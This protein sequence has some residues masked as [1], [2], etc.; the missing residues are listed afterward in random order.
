MIENWWN[1]PDLEQNV[2]KDKLDYKVFKDIL[3]TLDNIKPIFISREE[4]NDKKWNIIDKDWDSETLYLP[5]DLKINELPSIIYRVNKL[6][7]W[8]DFPK[9][10]STN[11]LK[12]KII[13]AVD[14]L[15]NEFSKNNIDQDE[16]KK[17]TKKYFKLYS[18]MFWDNEVSKLNNSDY[19]KQVIVSK[20]NEK[21][22]E[23]EIKLLQIKTKENLSELKSDIEELLSWEIQN[24]F[25]ESFYEKWSNNTRNWLKTITQEEVK[26]IKRNE[27]E[28]EDNNWVIDIWVNINSLDKHERLVRDKIWIDKMKNELDNIRTL[29]NIEDISSMEF[30]ITNKLMR[31]LKEYPYQL[32]NDWYGYEPDKILAYKEAYCVWFSHMWSSFLSELWINHKWLD[33]LQHSA[34]EVNIWWKK[35]LFDVTRRYPRL[36]EFEYWEKKW[37]FTEMNFSRWNKSFYAIPWNSEKIILSQIYNNK[38][39]NLSKWWRDEE[40]IKVYEESLELNPNSS[41]VSSNMSISLS[42]LWKID[43]SIEAAKKSLISYPDNNNAYNSL[44]LSYFKLWKYWDAIESFKDSLR[45][46]PNDSSTYNNI[47]LCL[48]KLWKN[49]E[50]IFSFNHAIKLNPKNIGA[51]D[52]LSE[53][54]DSVWNDKKSS[55]NKYISSLLSWDESMFE[56]S[57]KDEKERIKVYVDNNQFDLLND[58]MNT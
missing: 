2:F 7:Y 35:Y 3:D 37:N 28:T 27:K 20:D 56:F 48:Q 22:K 46:K 17:S 58:Y 57:Y 12:I 11:E 21:Y 19:R 31:V 25:K 44:W 10:A 34:L 6:T 41:E 9:E 14:V 23:Y 53:S 51:Y 8:D 45:L 30:E 1:I 40:A 54:F 15:F 24:H 43:K 5:V 4:Y 47:W 32:T 38:W 18:Q 42:K 26:E 52:S 50:A 16:I 55:L 13:L 49:D 33:I 36:K 39:A 29:W